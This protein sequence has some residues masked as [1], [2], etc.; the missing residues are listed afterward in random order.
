MN[1]TQ[2]SGATE[3]RRVP[4]REGYALWAAS[5][6]RCPNP[7]LSL[8]E[9]TISLM[10]PAV[11]NLRALDVACGTGRWM[12][13]LVACGAASVFGLDLSPQMLE[14]AA[15]KASLRGQ[16]VQGDC[17]ELP[18]RSGMADLILC[19]FVV[20]Y[21]NDLSGLMGELI[22]V[23]SPRAEIF[24]S[25]VHPSCHRR[26]WKRAFRYRDEVL[27][28]ENTKYSIA[29]I[30]RIGQASGLRLIDHAEPHWGE[31]EWQVFQMAGKMHVYEE[32]RR[33]PA[34]FV[35]RFRPFRAQ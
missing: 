22:R 31:P 28:I 1:S 25:D 30:V 10:L 19:S 33:D 7:L 34:I 18:I 24:L 23:A 2:Q 26:G 21:L 29:Q 14:C 5:Y 13:R 27:E 8:E 35:L 15:R 20:G 4:V 12:A 11:A 16:L 17:S 6:D 3:T 32:S 9:R